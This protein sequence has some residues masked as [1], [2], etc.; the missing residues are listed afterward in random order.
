MKVA[1]ADRNPSALDMTKDM[2]L[3]QS[4]SVDVLLVPMDLRL[5]KDIT[6]G[7]SSVI[8]KFGRI[9]YAVNCAG[10]LRT[11]ISPFPALTIMYQVSTVQL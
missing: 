3:K 7:I 1:L 10:G 2:I 6:S 11:R 5:D 8:E 9:D 4:P